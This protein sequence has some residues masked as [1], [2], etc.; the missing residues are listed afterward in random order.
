MVRHRRIFLKSKRN[1]A[2]DRQ[3]SR[4]HDQ[5]PQRDPA[6]ILPQQPQNEAQAGGI[7]HAPKIYKD[8]LLINW[9]QPVVAIDNFIR[10]MAPHPGAYTM[11]NDKTLKIYSSDYRAEPI[12]IPAGIM[13]TDNSTYMRF[14]AADGWL[15]IDE[16]QLEGKK[17]MDVADFLRGYRGE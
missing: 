6:I 10:G 12:S 2:Q 15:Y 3:Q 9:N 8:D 13:D 1:Q 14:A 7:K 11:L 4:K 5:R 16:L 17:R